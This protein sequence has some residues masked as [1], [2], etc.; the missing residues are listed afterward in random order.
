MSTKQ[1]GKK[2][3]IGSKLVKRLEKFK[4][5]LENN[6]PLCDHYTCHRLKRKRNVQ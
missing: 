5:A 4:A 6:G 3:S 2:R 1:P